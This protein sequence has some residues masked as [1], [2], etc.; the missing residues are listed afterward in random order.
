MRAAVLSAGAR[1]LEKML[2]GVGSGWRFDAIICACGHEM[3]SHGR[4][5]KRIKTVLGDITFRRT[6]YVCPSCGASRF[7][8]D[9]L[10]NVVGTGFSPGLRRLM[11]RA[12]SKVP[13]KEGRDDL[14]VY[15][16][17]EVSAKDV[18]RVAEGVGKKVEEWLVEERRELTENLPMPPQQKDI[19]L[20]YISYDGTGVPMVPWELAGRKGKQPD[21][22]SRT[23]EVKLGCVFTQTKTNDEGR[24][25]RDDASTTFVGAIEGC[26]EFGWRIYGEAVRRGLQRAQKVVVI[27]DGSKWIWNI[28]DTH[29]GGAVQIVDLYH[30]RQ[31]LYSL[32]AL[33]FS[34]NKL[35][36]K[37]E[38][39]WLTALDDGN[40]ENIIK[41]AAQLLPKSGKRRKLAKKEI[42]YFKNNSHRMRYKEFREQNLF[43]GSGVVE[44]GC[45]TI[46]GMRLKQSGMEWTVTGANSIIA[47]RCAHLSGRIEDFWEKR[48]A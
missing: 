35:K 23:R 3:A 22:S 7:L 40:V 38:L 6:R 32:A 25:V 29:F 14:K 47:L 15:G 28:A 39:K 48:A 37:Y 30:A 36:T 31:H 46:V 27:G 5:E 21:G 16:E 17:I 19:P 11:S 20:L 26:E 34:E 12:G 4:D 43:V 13:F 45:K 2:E 33:L 18:E 24:P 9:E 1:L 8:G 42:S 10:L 44:A 41:E